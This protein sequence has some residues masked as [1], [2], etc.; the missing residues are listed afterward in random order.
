MKM[1]ERM[2]MAGIISGICAVT[3]AIP[4]FWFWFGVSLAYPGDFQEMPEGSVLLVVGGLAVLAAVSAVVFT[5]SSWVRS[6]PGWTTTLPALAVSVG[7]TV[8]GLAF[9]GLQIQLSL[10]GAASS[11][12][13]FASETNPN[14]IW[15]LYWYSLFTVWGLS[16]CTAALYFHGLKKHQGGAAPVNM[17]R[18]SNSARLMQMVDVRHATDVTARKDGERR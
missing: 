9:F 11:E 1:E 17:C 14:A 12:Q 3:F 2:K 13:Y 4:H 15:G 5:H 16:L 8:W 18:P 6:L 7:L 10:N